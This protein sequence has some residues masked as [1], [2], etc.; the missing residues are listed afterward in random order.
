MKVKVVLLLHLLGLD[1]LL[2]GLF[3]KLALNLTKKLMS[4]S[5]SIHNLLNEVLAINDEVSN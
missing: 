1:G 3:E 5:N 2:L 4:W